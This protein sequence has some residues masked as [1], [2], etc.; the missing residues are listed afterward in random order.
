MYFI[1]GVLNLIAGAHLVVDIPH[2]AA[3]TVCLLFDGSHICSS[4]KVSESVECQIAFV[5]S[6]ISTGKCTEL[7]IT[8]TLHTKLEILS[9]Q[10]SSVTFSSVQSHFADRAGHPAGDK[11]KI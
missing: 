3:D 7:I 6:Y 5:L 9:S 11:K 1:A 10:N 2:L 4:D 8:R